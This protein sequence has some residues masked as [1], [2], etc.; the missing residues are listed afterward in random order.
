MNI[1]AL[2]LYL[3]FVS[4]SLGQILHN[5]FYHHVICKAYVLPEN[6]SS[7]Q[8]SGYHRGNDGNLCVILN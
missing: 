6:P 5:F 8:L 2:Y 1:D 7:H 3:S 4:R